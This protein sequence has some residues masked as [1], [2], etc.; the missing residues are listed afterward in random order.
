MTKGRHSSTLLIFDAPQ[1]MYL[2]ATFWELLKIKPSELLGCPMRHTPWEHWHTQSHTYVNKC[3][4]DFP[5]QDVFVPGDVRLT[6]YASRSWGKKTYLLQIPTQFQ[7]DPF[8]PITL[9]VLVR[10]PR[11]R[12]SLVQ[13]KQNN[14]FQMEFPG[15]DNLCQRNQPIG[16]GSPWVHVKFVALVLHS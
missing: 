15:L 7:M 1:T 5:I 2:T 10:F 6:M 13:D 4:G 8:L 3:G 11:H 12:L 14:T 9:N 16:L